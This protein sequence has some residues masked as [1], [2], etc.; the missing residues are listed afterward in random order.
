[1]AAVE[2][3][4]FEM[5]TALHTGI[6]H[7]D[8][9]RKRLTRRLFKSYDTYIRR[10]VPGVEMEESGTEI[11]PF[12]NILVVPFEYD[13]NTTDTHA[14]DDLNH[15]VA[16]NFR[17]DCEHADCGGKLSIHF[18]HNVERCFIQVN[19][20]GVSVRVDGVRETI[21]YGYVVCARGAVI[22]IVPLSSEDGDMVNV[23]LHEVNGGRELFHST[24]IIVVVFTAPS[25][26]HLSFH[27]APYV[28]KLAELLMELRVLCQT[29]RA[30]TTHKLLDWVCTQSPHWV[31]Q[32]VSRLFVFV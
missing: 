4:F 19:T 16:Y 1:M 15:V 5:I 27:D 31:H 21:N 26:C 23:V 7:H 24:N 13:D 8:K 11:C 29:G 3:N 22:E 32:H 14:Y 10:L 17:E 18:D 28:G 6:Q 20:D 30:S 12:D 25:I 9:A 2:T